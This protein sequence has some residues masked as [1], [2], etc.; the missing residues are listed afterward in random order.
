MG[1]FIFLGDYL[2]PYDD[3]GIPDEQ[4]YGSLLEIIDFKKTRP[5]NVTLLWGNHDLHYLYPGMMG[6]RYDLDNAERNAHLFRDNLALFK[7]SYEI[8]VGGKRFL[9]SHAGVGRKWITQA[10]PGLN[11]E[12]ISAEFFNDLIGYPPFMEAL[13]STSRLRGGSKPFGSMIWADLSEQMVEENR[14]PVVQVFGHTKVSQPVN[15][16]NQV[17]CLDCGNY[18]VMNLKTGRIYDCRD[19]EVWQ[20]PFPTTDEL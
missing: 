5:E 1:D 8:S 12:D 7:I 14:L 9:F 17:Y 4:A 3:E 15:R 20:F 19:R 16:G 11:E 2:D 13:V 18:F 10:F 6:S